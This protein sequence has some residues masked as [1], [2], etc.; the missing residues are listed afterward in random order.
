MAD[1]A[2]S[3]SAVGN[4]VRVQVPFPAYFNQRAV[5]YAICPLALC[6]Q[7]ILWRQYYKLRNRRVIRKCESV[8]A[9]IGKNKYNRE[10]IC[11][12]YSIADR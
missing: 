1:A 3:K 2:D 6:L 11:G 12:I 8:V 5:A 10:C 7:Y 9:N 4:H